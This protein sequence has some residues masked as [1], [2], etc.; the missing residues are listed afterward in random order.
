MLRCTRSLYSAHSASCCR[1]ARPVS[2]PAGTASLNTQHSLIAAA[3]ICV[4]ISGHQGIPLTSVSNSSAITIQHK[5][6][7]HKTAYTILTDLCDWRKFTPYRRIPIT[8][9]SN[10]VFLTYNRLTCVRTIKY[11]LSSFMHY[12]V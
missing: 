8:K 5:R 12:F 1:L 7:Q 4:G 11:I 2:Q 9:Q 6:I 10:N 3:G